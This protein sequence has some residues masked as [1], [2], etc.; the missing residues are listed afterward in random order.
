ML[1]YRGKWGNTEGLHINWHNSKSC[2]LTFIIKPLLYPLCKPNKIHILAALPGKMSG[3]AVVRRHLVIA[4]AVKA[5]KVFADHIASVANTTVYMLSII[6]FYQRQVLHIECG[7]VE[8]LA[9]AFNTL[10]ICS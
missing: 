1:Y 7:C 5:I 6:Q 3:D 10:H 9:I 4:D 8:G 2:L